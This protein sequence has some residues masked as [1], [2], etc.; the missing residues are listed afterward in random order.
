MAA[1][2]QTCY[3]AGVTCRTLAQISARP[4]LK[5]LRTKL[6]L[7]PG[8]VLRGNRILVADDDEA[9]RAILN[10]GL[11]RAGHEVTTVAD[12]Q[13]AWDALVK[14][15]FDLLVTDHDMPHLQGLDLIRRVRVVSSRL[16][17]ILMS[18][19]MPWH[20]DDLQ[21]LLRPGVT[22][23]KPFTLSAMIVHVHTLLSLSMASYVAVPVPRGLPAA[24]AT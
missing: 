9:L 17:I 1:S 14:E 16:P 12:G 24:A 19:S 8:P 10:L 18:G 3:S 23:E 22:L 20:E 13:A 21:G 7:T 11:T 5:T 4:T 6:V 2:P 15:T